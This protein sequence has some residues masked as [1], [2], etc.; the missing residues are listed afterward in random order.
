MAKDHIWQPGQPHK[1][2]P[3][4]DVA[5]ASK[6]LGVARRRL[7]VLAQ[8]GE[9]VQQQFSPAD[10]VTIDINTLRDIPRIMITVGGVDYVMLY[11]PVESGNAIDVIAG[12]LTGG[13]PTPRWTFTN[14][15][16]GA[17]RVLLHLGNTTFI[18]KPINN[19]Y[20]GA[21]NIFTVVDTAVHGQDLSPWPNS[22]DPAVD[23]IFGIASAAYC[24]VVESTA[25][26]RRRIG[27]LYGYVRASDGRRQPALALS[28]DGGK[29][30][31]V[32]VFVVDVEL[33]GSPGTFTDVYITQIIFCG[34]NRIALIGTA[35]NILPAN[36]VTIVSSNGGASWALNISS[37]TLSAGLLTCCYI[38]GTAVLAI[39]NR[40]GS[41]YV[42]RKTYLSTNAGATFS[43]VEEAASVDSTIHTGELVCVAENSAVYIS[44]TGYL[45][46]TIDAGATWEQITPTALKDDEQQPIY[47]SPSSLSVL[48]TPT[49]PAPLP[50][51]KVA[52]DY[53]AL[54]GLAYDTL[55]HTGEGSGGVPDG[56]P[57][58]LAVSRDGG[59]TWTLGAAIGTEVS[60]SGGQ[61]YSENIGLL[62]KDRPPFPIF[63]DLHK[64]G[65]DITDDQII[66]PFFDV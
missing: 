41:L 15:R 5:E 30:F 53:T 8:Q 62:S 55:V 14:G 32:S 2:I 49:I 33:S 54:T 45:H 48:E 34:E 23:Y 19:T 58:R 16:F 37:A 38:G 59:R 57:L 1:F 18:D 10:G 65:Y 63:P 43:L 29:S 3:Q 56:R 22:T 13:P 9:F 28:N 11:N 25:E 50:G 66:N 20:D 4:G 24:G 47:I 12:K 42:P 60:P 40:G 64:N 36:L 31:S 7:A 17:D 6:W 21:R 27:V 52:A 46:R 61:N 51:G 39:A 26:Y 35:Q 44:I